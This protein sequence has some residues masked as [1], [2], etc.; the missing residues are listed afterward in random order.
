MKNIITLII[1]LVNINNLFA[2]EI[3]EVTVTVN[4]QGK[5]KDEAKFNA[6]RNAIEN[7][8]GAFIS[9]NTSVINDELVIDE[10]ASIS[11]G[12]IKKVAIISEVQ[13]P[14]GSYT[15]LLNA[16][17][18]LN[19]LND[20]CKN[21]GVTTEFSGDL[22]AMNIKMQKFRK[23]NELKIVR[24]LS[25]IINSISSSLFDFKIEV[26][27]PKENPASSHWNKGLWDIPIL[28]KA[29]INNNSKK[30]EDI[31]IK[32]IKEISLNSSDEKELSETN[33]TVY[34]ILINDKVYKL[35]NLNSFK[36]IH[37]SFL[38]IPFS[39][40]EFSI[41]N[42]FKINNGKEIR[43]CLLERNRSLC[44]FTSIPDPQKG[45]KAFVDLIYPIYEVKDFGSK[46]YINL[47][48]ESGLSDNRGGSLFNEIKK[49]IGE[50]R[51]LSINF[52]EFPKTEVVFNFNN[53]LPLDKISKISQYKIEPIK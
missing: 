18:S 45:Y 52:K 21:K 25:G 40:L 17:V 36:I 32:T 29:T 3:N 33:Q 31:F 1:L 14:D 53:T 5:T 50:N 30:I 37:E 49:N 11:S 51:Y 46:G 13:L 41:N 47:Y 2:G 27:K 7:A 28:I 8:F 19:K 20:L 12:N 35:R 44:N 43:Q 9:S 22:F 39:A 38:N 24:N 42:G 23:E 15:T 26:S 34:T 10:M 4:G 48:V 6:L 16:T